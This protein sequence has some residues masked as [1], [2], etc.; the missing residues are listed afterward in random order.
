MSRAAVIR[1]GRLDARG[2]LIE[3]VPRALQDYFWRSCLPLTM[4]LFLLPMIV[5]YEVG[6][7]YYASD[8]STRTETR[9][10]AFNLM[11]R[12]LGW[13]G[14][15]G[16]YLPCFTVVGILLAWH[17]ARRDAWEFK[18]GTAALMILESILL[19]VPI[20]ALGRILGYV[21]P[22]Y[23][24]ASG[25]K[26]GIVLALGAG[27]YE[28]LVFRLIA[29]TALD[30]LLVDLLKLHRR[31]AMAAII[32]TTSLLFASYHYWSQHS[33]LFRW[34]DFVFRTICGFYFG[35]LLLVRGFAVTSG[36]HCAYDL[37]YFGMRAVIPV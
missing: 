28:E 25:W 10:L 19:A 37:F 18:A 6:T 23:T 3:G 30:M 26:S 33:E 17:I 15:T 8:W 21:M 14:A 36:C 29:F 5:L 20:V 13:F 35:W 1:G 32:V 2:E 27:V 11:R 34:R 31:W 24:S 9:V 7:H 12:F 16:Q 4:L 22:L